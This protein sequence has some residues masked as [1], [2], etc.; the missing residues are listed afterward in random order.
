MQEAR[1]NEEAIARK[2]QELKDMHTKIA[3]KESKRNS[4]SPRSVTSNASGRFVAQA[5]TSPRGSIGASMDGSPRGGVHRL[6]T[7]RSSASVYTTASQPQP[8]SQPVA[9]VAQSVDGRSTAPGIGILSPKDIDAVLRGEAIPAGRE[10]LQAGTGVAGGRRGS[11]APPAEPLPEEL[12]D[13]NDAATFNQGRRR[14]IAEKLYGHVQPKVES[15]RAS[16]VAAD[17]TNAEAAAAAA[18]AAE[19]LV[20]GGACFQV[21]WVVCVKYGHQVNL[22]TLQVKAT[23]EECDQL[24]ACKVSKEITELNMATEKCLVA[25]AF[26]C[27]ETSTYLQVCIACPQHSLLQARIYMACCR[28]RVD[29]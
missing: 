8:Q 4:V 17:Q 27:L 24:L 7:Y 28:T 2:A 14:S 12:Q 5:N 21:P 13:A 22:T 29:K 3:E 23:V 25:H 1:L 10:F 18:E 16:A 9:S 19:H 20:R 6:T 11:Y 15:R 26:G